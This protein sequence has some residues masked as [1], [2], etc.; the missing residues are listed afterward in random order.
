MHEQLIKTLQSLKTWESHK[1]LW[2]PSTS[3]TNDDLKQIWR[4]ED[5]SPL[6]EVT[7]LQTNG[8]GQY[9]RKWSSS[10]LGQ[11]LMFSFTIDVKDYEF[12][13]S[14]IAGVAIAIALEELGLKTSD[15]WL[16]WPN[17]IWVN[18]KKLSGILTESTTIK[19]GIR[20][21]VGIGINI[22]PLPDKTVNATSLLENGVKTTREEVLNAFIKSFD[23]VFAYSASQLA[24]YWKKYAGQFFQRKFKVQAPNHPA[25]IAKAISIK[26]DGRLIVKTSEEEEKEIIAAS[27]F[28]I[29]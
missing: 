14:M 8:K 11:C 13:I 25:F 17:D 9:N 16:K 21:V 27:L 26:E 20:S 23:K 2:L 24:Q 3:S 10:S 28:P 18:D 22:L 12:P 4:K 15:F 1:L 5:F 19:E 7:D 29:I 6:I